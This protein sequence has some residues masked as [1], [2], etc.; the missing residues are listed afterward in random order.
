MSYFDD[1]ST[2]G[3]EESKDVLGG[4]SV[5]DS[6]VYKGKVKLAYAGKSKDGAKFVFLSIAMP[7]GK[8]YR[9]TIYVTSKAGNNFYHPKGDTSKKVSLP[10]FVLA[11]D[12]SLLLSDKELRHQEFEDKVVNVYDPDHKKEMPKKV[13]VLVDLLGKD[14]AVGILKRLEDVTVK[15]GNEYVPTGKTRDTNAIDK[16]FHAESMKTVSEY[17]DVKDEAEFVNKWLAKNKGTVRDLTKSEAKSGRP[18][19]AAG[20]PPQAGTN[21]KPRASLFGS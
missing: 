19:A 11:N 17:R 13:P 6:D 12:I 21:A 14:I 3:L 7:D 15:Q 20:G 16:I 4:Y 8:E 10:G 5:Y 2:D 18:G 1:L 9:E